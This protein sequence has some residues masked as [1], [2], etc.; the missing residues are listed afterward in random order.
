MY[1]NLKKFTIMKK[2][3]FIFL[4]LV[5]IFMSCSNNDDNTNNDNTSGDVVQSLATRAYLNSVMGSAGT[6]SISSGSS[7]NLSF[8]TVFPIEVTYSNG[9]TITIN[10]MEGLKEAVYNET[11]ALHISNIVF[12]FSVTNSDNDVVI[13]N[14]EDEFESVL[15]SIDSITT[16]DEFFDSITCFE[17]IFP[18]SVIDNDGQTITISDS[19]SLQNMLSTIS[20]SG[21][22]M[23]F[24][25]PFQIEYSGEVVTIQDVWEFYSYVDCNPDGWYCT[26]DYNP[27]CVETPN[28]VLQFDNPCWA[29][30]AGYSE[31][32][33]VSC[34]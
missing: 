23:D 34:E 11:S 6:L 33:F 1:Y 20:E 15:F 17:F 28:G 16:I 19:E 32:D 2:I 14:N 21:Y 26:F 30:Q 5:F 29:I 7:A 25:Y 3:K 8:T 18:L 22:W 9:T 24:V 4:S 13:I 31:S 12:P 10:S 27:T